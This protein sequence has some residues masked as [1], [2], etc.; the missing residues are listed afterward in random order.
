MHMSKFILLALLG[1]VGG[2]HAHVTLPPGGATAGSV[3]T[4]AFR[5]GH[6]CKDAAV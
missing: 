3:Y 5:V 4:A 2:V 6:A 1:A